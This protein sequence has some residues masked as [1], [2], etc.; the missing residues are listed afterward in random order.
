[1]TVDLFPE[2]K[3]K[4]ARLYPESPIHFFFLPSLSL[5]KSICQYVQLLASEALSGSLTCCEIL[6]NKQLC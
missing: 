4:K 6:V 3:K 5:R 1:M 2:K